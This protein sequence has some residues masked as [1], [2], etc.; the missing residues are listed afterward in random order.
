MKLVLL[1]CLMLLVTRGL[2]CGGWRASKPRITIPSCCPESKSP[3][4]GPK[5]NSGAA[6]CYFYR[7]TLRVKCI[8]GS[9]ERTCTAVQAGGNGPTPYGEYLIGTQSTST[10]YAGLDWYNLYPKKE[11]NSGYYPY[12]QPNHQGRSHMGLHPGRVSLGC[13]T[14]KAGGC[15][16][17]DVSCYN[18][19]SCW[20]QIKSIVNS[21]HMYY[22]GS[23]YSGILYVV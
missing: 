9:S 12:H 7:S 16:S 6:V 18:R 10:N 4:G 8:K 11:D 5:V 3:S 22:R 19:D 23:S 2:G 21:G 15:S 1:G 20:R 14:V 17:G 13:V